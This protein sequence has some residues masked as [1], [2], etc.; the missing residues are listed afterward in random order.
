MRDMQVRNRFNPDGGNALFLFRIRSCAHCQFNQFNQFNIQCP[1]LLIVKK[2]FAFHRNDRWATRSWA[3]TARTRIQ[4]TLHGKWL[5]RCF[6]VFEFELF[7]QSSI[8]IPSILEC[9]IPTIR[10]IRQDQQ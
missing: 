5:F 7:S 9:L 1:N 2:Y 10:L 6:H 8:I 4:Y 3:A